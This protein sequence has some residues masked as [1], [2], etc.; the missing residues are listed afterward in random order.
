[1]ASLTK[2]LTAVKVHN[3]EIQ[4][5]ALPFPLLESA[6]FVSLSLSS[7]GGGFASGSSSSSSSISDGIVTTGLS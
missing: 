6:I 2:I 7:R 3:E 1:M 5:Y 4:L